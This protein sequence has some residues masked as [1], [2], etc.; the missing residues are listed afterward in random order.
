[1]SN[2]LKTI[3][4]SMIR[5]Q[6]FSSKQRECSG[7]YCTDPFHFR[8]IFSKMHYDLSNGRTHFFA[9]RSRVASGC[10]FSVCEK[11]LFDGEFFEK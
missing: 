9:G 4:M 11:I 3:G 7:S 6:A 8:R 2:A 10:I 1:M 5:R